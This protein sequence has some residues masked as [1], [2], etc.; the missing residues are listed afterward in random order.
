[1]KINELIA[2][3]IDLKSMTKIRTIDSLGDKLSDMYDGDDEEL[4]AKL[5]AKRKS[6]TISGP[7]VVESYYA[8]YSSIDNRYEREEFQRQKRSAEVVGGKIKRLKFATYVITG[9]TGDKLS[10]FLDE[11]ANE[12]Q[13]DEI[14]T[15]YGLDWHFNIYK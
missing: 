9:I 6:T 14:D 4:K 12:L 3:A 8:G 1:M 10:E 5:N 7:I 11:Y 2:E 15:Q 13:G